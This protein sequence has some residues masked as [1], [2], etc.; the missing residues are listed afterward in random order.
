MYLLFSS[1][2]PLARSRIS[3]LAWALGVGR[4]RPV[5]VS[6]TYIGYLVVSPAVCV[7]LMWSLWGEA[8]IVVP[9]I[10]IRISLTLSVGT[11]LLCLQYAAGAYRANEHESLRN[12]RRGEAA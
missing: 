10:S 8:R 11:R 9:P 7:Q 1:C 2:S 5:N 3:Q 4:L 6:L 12:R